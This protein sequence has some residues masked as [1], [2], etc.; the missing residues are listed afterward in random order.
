[1]Q[2][3]SGFAVLKLNSDFMFTKIPNE[4]EGKGIDRKLWLATELF[5]KVGSLKFICKTK[6]D[7]VIKRDAWKAQ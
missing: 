7:K 6:T 5:Y 1:M 3:K 2:V 4:K